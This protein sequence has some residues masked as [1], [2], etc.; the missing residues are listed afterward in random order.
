MRVRRLVST[1]A[2]DC[3]TNFGSWLSE[4]RDGRGLSKLALSKKAGVS[5]VIIGYLE[6]GV[7][8]PSRGMVER[9][10]LA[11]STDEQYQESIE[12]LVDEA[13]IAAGF[14]PKYHRLNAFGEW[15]R[16]NRRA[17]GLTLENLEERSGLSYVTIGDWE[18]GKRNPRRENIEPVVLSLRYEDQDQESVERLVDEALIA[19][20]F[21]PKYREIERIPDEEESEVLHTYADLPHES[22]KLVRELLRTMSRHARDADSEA[23]IGGRGY[24][25]DQPDDTVDRDEQDSP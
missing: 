19:A 12:R 3:M 18:R 25:T 13:L 6:T 16:K 20:G 23:S 21:A 5:D 4:R 8:N 2:N 15:L 24:R 14:A 17:R 7:R 22:R 1:L 10:A 9:I 11:L